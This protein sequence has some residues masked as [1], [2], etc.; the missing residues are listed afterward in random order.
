MEGLFSFCTL[1]FWF[2]LMGEGFFFILRVGTGLSV[3]VEIIFRI[4]IRIVR[5][6]RLCFEKVIFFFSGYFFE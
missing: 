1:R 5:I 2:R 4:F 3:I 6:F